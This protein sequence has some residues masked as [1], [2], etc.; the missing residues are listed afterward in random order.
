MRNIIILLTFTLITLCFGQV[1]DSKSQLKILY[2]MKYEKV[3]FQMKLFKKYLPAK[4][5]EYHSR[6]GSRNEVSFDAKMLGKKI[7]NYTINVDND[8]LSISWIK[9]E[10]IIND[11]IVDGEFIETK[12]RAVEQNVFIGDKR[13]NVL[14]YDCVYFVS[15]DDSVKTEGFLAPD[16]IVPGDFQKYGLPLEFKATSKTDKF[17]VSTKADQIIIEPLDANMFILTK[18]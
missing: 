7:L 4:V 16:I 1:P 13:K 18:D 10:T 9:T 17:V 3:P 8:S 2:S 11:S 12:Y 14:G 15:E 5:V 6:L